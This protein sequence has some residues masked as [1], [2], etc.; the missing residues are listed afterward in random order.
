MIP[1]RGPQT[2]CLYNHC[3]AIFDVPYTLAH[4]VRRLA[5][6]KPH[7]WADGLET[8]TQLLSWWAGNYN[9]AFERMGWT[10]EPHIWADGLGTTTLH[11]SWC[12]GNYTSTFKLMCNSCMHICN[13][14]CTPA[15]LEARL[16]Y[17]MYTSNQLACICAI[18][19]LL[20][21]LIFS[22]PP[23]CLDSP[24]LA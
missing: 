6:W 2:K 24:R 5:S 17:G 20:H 11:L 15:T 13:R 12:T 16:H 1:A 3:S 18:L 19:H 14:A 21:L 8:T 23:T 4:L 22:S 7:I 10:V 9:P